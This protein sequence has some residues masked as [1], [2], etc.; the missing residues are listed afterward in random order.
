MTKVLYMTEN[1]PSRKASQQFTDWLRANYPDCSFVEI[2]VAKR[3]YPS[4]NSGRYLGKVE[5]PEAWGD[6]DH[7]SDRHTVFTTARSM[8]AD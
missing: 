3:A 2:N 7:A 1:K 6:A 8:L 4:Q 5:G